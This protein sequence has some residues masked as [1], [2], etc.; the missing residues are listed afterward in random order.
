MSLLLLLLLLLSLLSLLSPYGYFCSIIANVPVSVV[1]VAS[2]VCG[3]GR[4]L[5]LLLLLPLSLLLLFGSFMS[6][7]GREERP[8]LCD[9]LGARAL[10]NKELMYAREPAW[11]TPAADPT[12]HLSAL[13]C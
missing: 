2:G 7:A 11:K 5:L 8:Q 9:E 13:P 6:A 3:V 4:P 1:V 12:L 10:T